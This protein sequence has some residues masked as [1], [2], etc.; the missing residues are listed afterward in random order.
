M[1]MDVPSNSTP[2]VSI[3]ERSPPSAL[4]KHEV[5]R[6]GLVK[7]SRAESVTGLLDKKCDI[8]VLMKAAGLT[9][10]KRAL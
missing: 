7:L 3:E 8:A 5:A 4:P 10:I 1:Q 6:E 2:K 9:P